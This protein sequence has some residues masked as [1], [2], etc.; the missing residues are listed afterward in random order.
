MERNLAILKQDRW[1]GRTYHYDPG[2]GTESFQAG[3]NVADLEAKMIYTFLEPFK[4][5]AAWACGVY[6]RDNLNTRQFRMTRPIR[7]NVLQ[8]IVDRAPRMIA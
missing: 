3:R 7:P 2:V 1:L 8:R 4:Q 5:A 6:R